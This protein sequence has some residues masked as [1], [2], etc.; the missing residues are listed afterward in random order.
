MKKQDS[1]NRKPTETGT[2]RGAPVRPLACRKVRAV[3]GEFV[4]NE[5]A[6]SRRA[7]VQAHIDAC[8]ECARQVQAMLRTRDLLARAVEQSPAA[9]LTPARREA[10]LTAARKERPHAPGV[11]SPAR[12]GWTLLAGGA[13][14]RGVATAAAVLLIVGGL[15]ASLLLPALRKAGLP[16]FRMARYAPTT[17]RR[18]TAIEGSTQ[19]TAQARLA[20]DAAR[21]AS[22]RREGSDSSEM[23]VGGEKPRNIQTKPA[24]AGAGTPDGMGRDGGG[25]L[26]TSETATRFF[27]APNT[28]GPALR[29]DE[30]GATETAEP[31]T[32]AAVGLAKKHG[33]LRPRGGQAEPDRQ[34]R[35]PRTGTEPRHELGSKRATKTPLADADGLADSSGHVRRRALRD[36]RM[37]ETTSNAADA[38]RR[39]SLVANPLPPKLALRGLGASA[40]PKMPANES[41]RRLAE[42]KLSVLGRTVGQPPLR[43]S[44][45]ESAVRGLPNY[46]RNSDE[47]L[48][49]RRTVKAKRL[50]NWRGRTDDDASRPAI[51]PSSWRRTARPAAP[52]ATVGTALA[53]DD[54]P[55]RNT[56]NEPRVLSAGAVKAPTKPK[57][58]VAAAFAEKMVYGQTSADAIVARKPTM[59]APQAVPQDAGIE[60][61]KAETL[62][63]LALSPGKSDAGDVVAPAAGESLLAFSE[64]TRRHVS[65]LRIT[66]ERQHGTSAAAAA[67]APTRRETLA[68]S[69]QTT[70]PEKPPAAISPAT[71]VGQKPLPLPPPVRVNPFVLTARDRFSTFAL[72][73]DT[74]SYARTRSSIRAGRLPPPAAVRPEE[75]VNAFDY[76]YARNTRSAFAVDV[77]GAPSPFTR[78]L[79]LLKVG[80]TARNVGRE[81][82]K[83]AH[84]V[85]AVDASGSMDRPDRLGLVRYALKKLVR[86]LRP[87]DRVSLV[88]Y[89]TTAR[90][91]LDSVPAGRQAVIDRAVDAIQCRGSTNLLE[92][93]EAAYT[94]ARKRFESGGINRVILCSDG[95]ANVGPD[96]AGALLAR[97]AD[98]RKWGVT[99]TVVGVGTGAYNDNLL[100][101]LADR[102]DGAYVFLDSKEEARRV[103]VAQLGGTLQ[104]VARDAKIQVEFNPDRVR[105]YRLIGYENR[106]IADKNFRNDSV[107]AGEVGSGRSAT[108]LYELE[109]TDGR[110]GTE[111]DGRDL[112]TVYVRY[113]SADTGRIEETSARIRADAVR[114]R[115]PEDSPYFWLAVCVGRFAEVLRGSPYAAPADLPRIERIATELA[116]A[117][118]LDRRIREFRELVDR[119]RSLIAAR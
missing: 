52:A 27:A 98:Y 113:R 51:T 15:V 85:F 79:T 114:E 108:A 1:E 69:N 33:S 38:A 61:K 92:G 119:T 5:L 115:T 112:G 55:V 16:R 96:E 21:A 53:G 58:G 46:R 83:P 32:E 90:L 3:L 49:R 41:A 43:G 93:L 60:S 100:E 18:G 72:E 71:D 62:D 66:P 97:V 22:L 40:L 25:M 94:L 68:S 95:V 57:A 20:N 84:L 102:G 13:T 39:S 81:A 65:E 105:R 104:V 36:E 109:L 29:A 42:D 73:T 14:A 111:R 7:A 17:T 77:A 64:P 31:K 50:S 99:L 75:F 91:I 59:R 6:P 54:R 11:P 44:A 106:D 87:K 80:V 88:V 19:R 45:G 116:K 2:T 103:F 78:G 10:L 76:N 101:Q 56:A 34:R 118:P 4:F 35:S 9:V 48:V 82:M 12:R 26:A 70:E 37:N 86:E 63:R 30:S 8:P 107:D 67:R 89:A 47:K 28:N 23:P 24:A 117:L 110:S 74:A